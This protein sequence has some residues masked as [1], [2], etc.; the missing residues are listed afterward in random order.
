MRFNPAFT[1]M[2]TLLASLGGLTSSLALANESS[3]QPSALVKIL[4]C[5]YKKFDHD[6]RHCVK[7][8]SATLKIFVGEPSSPPNQFEVRCDGDTIYEGG[9]FISTAREGGNPDFGIGIVTAIQN[10][11]PAFPAVWVDADFSPGAPS[12]R[13]IASRLRFS[14]E[15]VLYG[16]CNHRAVVTQ[17]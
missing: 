7:K 6:G 9:G 3:I 15:D 10:I 17:E 16:T 4:S 13:N 2:I 11:A 5:E 14:R 1:T 8:C 12:F